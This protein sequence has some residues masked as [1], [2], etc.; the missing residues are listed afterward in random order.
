M[1]DQGRTRISRFGTRDFV[2]SLV[3]HQPILVDR[4]SS[5]ITVGAVEEDDAPAVVRVSQQR[6]QVLL[7]APGLRENYR[8]LGR[9]QPPPVQQ[10]RAPGLSEVLYPWR[11]RGCWLPVI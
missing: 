3:P 4:Q 7:R 1:L 6:Q 10:M 11:R 2:G 5:S 9:A 8:F